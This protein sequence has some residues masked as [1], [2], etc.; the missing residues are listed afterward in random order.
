MSTTKVL[1]SIRSA[2]LS[3]VKAWCSQRHDNGDTDPTLIPTPLQRGGMHTHCRVICVS[4]QGDYYAFRGEDFRF[5]RCWTCLDE[6]SD[7]AEIKMIDLVEAGSDKTAAAV[8]IRVS[9]D[10]QGWLV[11]LKEQSVPWACISAAF[12]SIRGQDLGASQEGASSTN[13]LDVQDVVW[14]GYVA[15]NRSCDGPAMAKC[16]HDDFRLTSVRRSSDS[17]AT[18]V[19]VSKDDFV[20]RVSRRYQIPPHVDYARWKDDPRAGHLDEWMWA[21]LAAPRVAMV[22][23]KIG[24]PPYLW[25]DVLT[26]IQLVDHS[27]VIV[28][29]SSCSEPF[30]EDDAIQ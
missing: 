19:I 13:L 10:T 27:W 21:K 7:H 23:L 5:D 24:H 22:K 29:K 15:N 18:V 25:T 17:E 28:H 9:S 4:S 1:D 8:L 12:G 26:C 20:D 14:N 16:L 2:A 11:F 3:C 6:G 30:L